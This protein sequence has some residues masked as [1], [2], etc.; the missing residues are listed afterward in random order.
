GAEVAEAAVAALEA[1]GVDVVVAD[2]TVGTDVAPV[3]AIEPVAEHLPEA[4]A[5][6]P[7]EEPQLVATPVG[8]DIEAQPEVEA[9]L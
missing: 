5:P 1:A 9:E 8:A 6:E 3:A 4:V 7:A 2:T